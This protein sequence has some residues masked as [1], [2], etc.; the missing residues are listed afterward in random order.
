MYNTFNLGLQQKQRKMS[1]SEFR[2]QHFRINSKFQN[3]TYLLYKLLNLQFTIYNFFVYQKFD[4]FKNTFYLTIWLSI[5]LVCE[6]F[7][8]ILKIRL[9]IIYRI[10]SFQIEQT[11]SVWLTFYKSNSRRLFAWLSRPIYSKK[12]FSKSHIDLSSWIISKLFIFNL[13][14]C[15]L[16]SLSV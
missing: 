14:H 11:D 3:K 7:V 16:Q 15:L 6:P 2:H 10:A 5:P 13:I 1:W 4:M 9:R 12:F 8:R